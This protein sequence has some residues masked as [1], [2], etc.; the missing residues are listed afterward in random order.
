MPIAHVYG[1]DL[2]DRDYS[3]RNAYAR[4]EKNHGEIAWAMRESVHRILYTVVHSAGMNGFSA[5]TR[6]ITI[7]PEW[8]YY[9]GLFTT[10]SIA[11]LIASALILITCYAFPAVPDAIV[12]FVKK[13]K[14]SEEG[15][16]N[17]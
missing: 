10:F 3:G 9:L 5:N 15:G 2:P 8:Q 12:R 14:S 6:V 16:N 7:T 11:F 1:T 13:R 17:E 4:F